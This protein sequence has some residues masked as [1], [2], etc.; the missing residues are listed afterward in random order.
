MSSVGFIGLGTMGNHIAA[1]LHRY[2]LNSGGSAALVWNR[3]EGK[4]EAHA[5]EHGTVAAATL[6]EFKDRDVNKS[7]KS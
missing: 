2:S 4:A 6:D 7:L 1:H 3:S 5:A